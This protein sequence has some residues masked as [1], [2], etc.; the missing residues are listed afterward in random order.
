MDKKI[1][2]C[3]GLSSINDIDSFIN[4]GA[5]EFYCGVIDHVWLDNFNYIVALNRRPWPNANLNNFDELR[6][7]VQIA[8]GN[9]CKIFYTLNE[10][11]YTNMQT[12]YIDYYLDNAIK[13]NVDAIIFAD[14]GLAKYC[15]KKYPNI[16]IHISTGGIVFNRY[17]IEFYIKELKPQRIILPREVS[18]KEVEYL[19]DKYND[20]E[21][22]AFIKNE[23][24]TYIDGVCNYIHGINYIQNDEKTPIN[25]PCNLSQKIVDSDIECSYYSKEELEIRLNKLTR[26]KRDCGLCAI[27][28]LKNSNVCSLK[29]VGRDTN[30]NNILKDI[31]TIKELIAK[32]NE[33]HLE[34]A[35]SKYVKNKY[36]ENKKNISEGIIKCYYPE[37]LY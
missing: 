4:A 13:S 21:F 14:V 7:V 25:P 17:T 33:I 26:T 31:N 34:K 20:I 1:S 29:L 32:T 5:D 24:C 35:Y 37:V 3:T 23:G 22:E 28:T 8:H 15:R 27:Y 36:C 10:H 12:K 16:A 30:S 19:T 9:D 2:I 6:K 11:T 18:L